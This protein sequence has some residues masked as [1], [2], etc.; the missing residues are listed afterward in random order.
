MLRHLH[1]R[2]LMSDLRIWE[3]TRSTE[4]S[5]RLSG[6]CANVNTAV[7]FPV[8][9]NRAQCDAC[10]TANQTVWPNYVRNVVEA[11][12]KNPVVV[13]EANR[14]LF[15][16]LHGPIGNPGPSEKDEW[17]KARPFWEMAESFVR[18]MASRG[19]SGKRVS[20][21]ILQA[22][23]LSCFGEV[24][25]ATTEG[26]YSKLMYPHLPCPAK[27][28]GFS[29]HKG[30]ANTGGGPCKNLSLSKDGQHHYC[31]ACRCGDTSLA[32]LDSHVNP[33]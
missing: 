9:V 24:K 12:R 26:S 28:I 4:C 8:S 21:P 11:V 27:R 22:R 30:D 1:L 6:Q 23:E 16:E 20:L 2:I 25:S 15:Q 31:N 18:S 7:G 19:L 32:R 3:E 17:D 13:P 10:F 5:A 14:E 33:R 29:N